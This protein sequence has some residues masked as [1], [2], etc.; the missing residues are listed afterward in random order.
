M[1]EA[2]LGSVAEVTVSA[3]GSVKVNLGFI[4]GLPL[5]GPDS[6]VFANDGTMLISN[7][8]AGSISRVDPSTRHIV[9]IQW[10]DPF[11]GSATQKVPTVT[12]PRPP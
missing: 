3:D 5:S 1:T 8:S 7:F 10:P 12:N 11:A 6:A 9:S 4:T 2:G